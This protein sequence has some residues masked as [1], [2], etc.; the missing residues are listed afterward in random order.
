MDCVLGRKDVAKLEELQCHYLVFMLITS[1]HDP[2]EWEN[3]HGSGGSMYVSGKLPTFPSPNL[4][5]CPEQE[6]SANVRFGEG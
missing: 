5:F 6:V 1:F 2:S 3:F 4:T